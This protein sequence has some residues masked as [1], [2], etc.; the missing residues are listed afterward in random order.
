MG[1]THMFN[2]LN[3]TDIYFITFCIIAFVLLML[4]VI[5][6]IVSA[7]YLG[8]NV[9]PFMNK[10]INGYY[11]DTDSL[12]FR[13]P[14]DR[15]IGVTALLSL[16]KNNGLNYSTTELSGLS[17]SFILMILD[18]ADDNE[19]AFLIARLVL[20]VDPTYK[21]AYIS[22]LAA[23]K[24]GSFNNDSERQMVY[25][26]LMKYFTQLNKSD[27]SIGFPPPLAKWTDSL[28]VRT[29]R[30]LKMPAQSEFH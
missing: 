1:N 9:S 24:S 23:N 29:F 10:G 16:L 18:P 14:A 15:K 20:L 7:V 25:D 2:G 30:T 17:D 21:T 26:L 11:Y 4:W 27:T 6:T 12:Q 22:V 8:A 3:N 28:L 19:L 5:Y 13:S